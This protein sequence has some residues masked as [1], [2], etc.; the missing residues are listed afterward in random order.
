MDNG[1]RP[2]ESIQAPTL[3]QA[4]RHDVNPPLSRL[5]GPGTRMRVAAGY[6]QAGGESSRG[7]GPDSRMRAVSVDEGETIAADSLSLLSRRRS[8]RRLQE[9]E[10][11]PDALE[12]IQEAILRTPSAYSV[13]LWHVVL[14]QERRRAFWNE[15][16]GGFRA[17][18]ERD[19]L[20]R[21][22]DRL[23]GFR[24]AAAVALIYED[25]DAFPELRDAWNLSDEVAHSF[26]QQGLGMVQLAI[27][28]ALTAE[29][30]VSS[31]QHW[32]WL[33][34]ER[35]ARF[36]HLPSE[37]YRLTATMPIGYPAEAPRAVNA[38]DRS[39][40]ISVDRGATD[41]SIPEILGRQF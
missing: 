36:L 40:I 19:R 39:R 30:L 34:Q 7:E 24:G 8:I 28:L 1:H 33:V 5:D 41:E 3:H 21:Y 25:R 15:I 12:R 29:G 9:G 20:G 16:E 10:L 38:P 23:D 18:L 4:T 35:L 26:V 6:P 31:L 2:A 27:W 17:G 11:T 13:P 37:R 32:D 22:L 14:I